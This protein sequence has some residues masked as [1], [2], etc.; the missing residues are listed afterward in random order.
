MKGFT[1]PCVL[2]QRR[3]NRRYAP[4]SGS[5]GQLGRIARR[6]EIE[7]DLCRWAPMRLQ[8]HHDEQRL[9]LAVRGRL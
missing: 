2:I 4:V 7:D 9:E 6:I 5:F 1:Y 8:E 3:P